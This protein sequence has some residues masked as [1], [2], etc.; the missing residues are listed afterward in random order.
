MQVEATK[1]VCGLIEV[2]TSSPSPFVTVVVVSPP[3]I[4]IDQTHFFEFST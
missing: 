4:A 1:A 3:L 2:I